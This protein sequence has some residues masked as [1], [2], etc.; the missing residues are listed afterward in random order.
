MAGEVKGIWYVV[1]ECIFMRNL[2]KLKMFLKLCNSKGQA[3]G[4]PL[5]HPMLFFSR[6]SRLR[7]R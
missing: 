5:L 1:E 7:V 2:L 6:S 3:Q 4:L